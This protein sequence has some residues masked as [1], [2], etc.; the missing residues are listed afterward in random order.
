MPA[1]LLEQ[2][3]GE[4]PNVS[5]KPGSRQPS[6]GEQLKPSEPNAKDWIPQD[7]RSEK[8]W[9]KHK[10]VGSALKSLVH[11]EKKLGTSVSIP[12]DKSSPEEVSAFRERLGVPKEA[13]GY[14]NEVVLPGEAQWDEA[15]LGEFNAVAHKLGL[16]PAQH[17]GMLEYYGA[18]L[19]KVQEAGAKAYADGEAAL[20]ESWGK[21]Y[22][23]NLAAA[24]AGL[25]AYDNNGAVRQL[26]K[27]AGLANH[28][29]I[30]EFMCK[31]GLEV[32]EDSTING[33]GRREMEKEEAQKNIQAIQR[34]KTDLFWQSPQIPGV[35]ER[36]EEVERWHKIVAGE[37]V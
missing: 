21:D 12:N 31:V 33:D 24:G 27:D 32:G 3:Q 5:E 19:G 30:L 17:K 10:D 16:T 34:D 14:K 9:D 8:I 35:K 13:T 37:K 15:G 18:S 1:D 28:P 11:L 22:D 2:A 4:Q 36:R 7:L 25:K 6:G 20:R 29:A 23:S 26:L